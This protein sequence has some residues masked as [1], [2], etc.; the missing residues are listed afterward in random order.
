M[1]FNNKGRLAGSQSRS[2]VRHCRD[3]VSQPHSMGLVTDDKAL[4]EKGKGSCIGKSGREWEMRRV[5]EDHAD[6]KLAVKV[7]RGLWRRYLG[8]D[9]CSDRYLNR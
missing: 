1:T 4:T 2:F 7:G 9:R 3:P 5:D 8:A 6:R